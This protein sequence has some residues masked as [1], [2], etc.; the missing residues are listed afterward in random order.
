MSSR[1]AAS[2]GLVAI[3]ALVAAAS[4]LQARL[5]RAAPAARTEPV[6][7]VRS[8]G[9]LTHL[10]LSYDA[11]LADIYWIR[12]IQYYGG[13]KLSD[14]P[15]K[16][17]PLLY[18]YLDLTTA[19]DP[20]FRA[21]YLFGSVF[22]AERPPAGAGRPD[23]AVRLLEKGLAAAPGDWTLAQQIGFVYYWWARD[24][25]TAAQWFERAAR[26]PDA[27]DWLVPMAALTL[28]Q[29]GDRQTSRQ[30]WQQ[31]LAT[32]DSAWL[33]DAAHFKL[34]QLDALDAID[35][36][37]RAVSAYTAARGAPPGTWAEL[38][39]AGRLRGVPLDPAGTALTLAP[40]GRVELARGSRLYPLPLESRPDAR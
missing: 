39:R 17:Y 31:V 20:R 6:L 24:Y 18:P 1:R 32:A 8:P 16:E 4:T 23:Q 10:A 34:A 36:V 25:R 15:V 12:T 38:I 21:A 13:T 3:A 28:T 33:R 11:L 22:L 40:D 30:L 37:Q 19:V 26:M 35:V 27:P 9:M 2:F 7:Y 14:A 5:E 29:G